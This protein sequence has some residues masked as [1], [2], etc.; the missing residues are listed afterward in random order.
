MECIYRCANAL[1]LYLT[2]LPVCHY[3]SAS[4]KMNKFGN[5]II[6]LRKGGS[7]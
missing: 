6:I 1:E 4:T 7:L 3:Y 5:Y 2:M